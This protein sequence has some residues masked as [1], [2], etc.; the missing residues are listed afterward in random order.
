MIPA[1]RREQILNVLQAEAAVSV[2]ELSQ[3]FGVSEVTI[4]RDLEF[5]ERE[6][7]LI[8]THGGAVPAYGTRFEPSLRERE[9]KRAAH[10][11]A[12]ASLARTFVQPGDSVALDAGTTITAVARQLTGI[13]Y[14]TIVTNNIQAAVELAQEPTNTVLLLGGVVSRQNLSTLSGLACRQAAEYRVDKAF[15][16]GAAFSLEDGLTDP[17]IEENEVKQALI[18]NAQEVTVVVDSSKLGR[19]AFAIVCRIA[20]IDRIITDHEADPDIVEKLRQEG[21]EVHL[22]R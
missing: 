4:R 8:R 3:R 22:A 11:M 2:Q 13:R 17:S 16:S 9:R 20:E 19:T 12:M 1:S 14:L 6:G 5:L 18:R 7:L 15:I 21:V 10:K